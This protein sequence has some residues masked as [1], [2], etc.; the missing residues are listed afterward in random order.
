[1]TFSLILGPLTAEE[2]EIIEK[3]MGER[4]F[5]ITS[6][7]IFGLELPEEYNYDDG[8]NLITV[9]CKFRDFLEFQRDN[10]YDLFGIHDG[11]ITFW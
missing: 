11:N 7:T 9:K 10:H 8:G 6:W 3:D 2:A 4:N 5:T 1:M